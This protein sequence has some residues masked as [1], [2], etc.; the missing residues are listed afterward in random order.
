MMTNLNTQ[1][2]ARRKVVNAN[3]GLLKERIMQELNLDE[4]IAVSGG[5]AT[6]RRFDLVPGAQ[7]EWGKMFN[8]ALNALGGIGS[9]IGIGIYDLTH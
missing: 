8:D 4:I 9:S 7:S 1:H 6:P 5:R 2:I 3:V